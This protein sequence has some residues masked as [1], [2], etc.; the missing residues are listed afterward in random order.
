MVDRGRSLTTLGIILR[1]IRTFYNIAIE[2]GLL[3]PKS[4]PF[5]QRKYSLPVSR[6][7]KKALP[8]QDVNRI[9]FYEPHTHEEMYGRDMWLFLYQGNGMNSKDMALLKFRNIDGDFIY[10]QRAKTKNTTRHRPKT[11]T[12][13]I[14]ADMWR[15]INKWGNKDNNPD[16]FIFPILNRDQAPMDQHYAI[17]SFTALIGRLTRPIAKALSLPLGI[18]PSVARH[19]HATHLKRA[20]ASTEFIQESLGHLNVNTTEYYLDSFEKE[21]KK[22][23]AEKLFVFTRNDAVAEQNTIS[24]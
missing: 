17:K 21:V 12:V 7:I 24:Q 22:E 2:D 15:I 5:G 18:K 3:N 23:F 20:G 10:F 9:Y 11:I 16:N 6:N 1:C 13:F 8:K 19:T 14:T 4:Y